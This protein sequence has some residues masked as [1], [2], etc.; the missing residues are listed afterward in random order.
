MSETIS[1]ILHRKFT[2][3]TDFIKDKEK[4]KHLPLSPPTTVSLFLYSRAKQYEVGPCNTE[5]PSIFNITARLKWNAWESCKLTK[6]KAMLEYFQALRDYI[7][8]IDFMQLNDEGKELAEGMLDAVTL[9]ELQTAFLESDA[10]LPDITTTPPSTEISTPTPQHPETQTNDDNKLASENTPVDS[11]FDPSTSGS[12]IITNQ[13]ILSIDDLTQQQQSPTLSQSTEK[14][15]VAMQEEEKPLQPILSSPQIRTGSR[16][17]RHSMSTKPYYPQTPSK[18]TPQQQSH[19]FQHSTP[20]PRSSLTSTNSMSPHN[21]LSSLNMSN[22]HRHSFSTDTQPTNFQSTP[23][24][25]QQSAS[26]SPIQDGFQSLQYSTPTIASTP[27]TKEIF[28]QLQ[29][30]AQQSN[31]KQLLLL[32]ALIDQR[33]TVTYLKLQS[34]KQQQMQ[35]LDLID[36]LQFQLH[37]QQEQQTQLSYSLYQLQ[38]EMAQMKADYDSKLSPITQAM[39]TN[40]QKISSLQSQFESFKQYVLDKLSWCS[41]LLDK[42]FP[43]GWRGVRKTFFNYVKF[44]LRC[45]TLF[46]VV[47]TIRDIYEW[48]CNSRFLYKSIILPFSQFLK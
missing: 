28:L 39:I 43:T 4:L 32:L 3:T 15:D 14:N 7:L 1:D 10:T 47:I 44:L 23:Q 21:Q 24:N 2:Y 20:Q 37:N 22:Q 27:S 29:Q 48:C 34:Y 35:N 8:T 45:Y 46:D 41:Q 33:E 42:K 30:H 38:E 16:S 18:V 36:S 6:W 9:D 40:T 11:E 31:N 12:P 13:S 25:P 17:A 26:Q 19:K 5:Q